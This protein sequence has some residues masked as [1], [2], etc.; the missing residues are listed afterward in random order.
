MRTTITCCASFWYA[1]EQK[2]ANTES[3]RKE[4]ESEFGARYSLLYEL[5]YY[6]AISSIVI[7]PMQSFLRN[8]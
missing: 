1:K 2:K 8:S 6:N 5:K 4:I 7:D 3:Q